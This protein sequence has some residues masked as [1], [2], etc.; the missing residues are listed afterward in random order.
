M[1]DVYLCGHGHWRTIGLD[2]PFTMIPK[3]TKF[4]VYTPVGRY[5]DPGCAYATMTGDTSMGG[6]VFSPDQTFEEF[7]TCPNTTLLPLRPGPDDTLIAIFTQAANQGKQIHRVN[8][9]T[10]LRTLLEQFRGCY[11]HWMACRPRLRDKSVE[12]G[13]FNDDYIPAWGMVGGIPSHLRNK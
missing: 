4:S 5:L 3:G 12:E 7:R 6:I 10:R 2:E 1:P 8:S 13:G 9:A 11:V